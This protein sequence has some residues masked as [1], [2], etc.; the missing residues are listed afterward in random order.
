MLPGPTLIKKCTA[1]CKPIKEYT[2]A[3]GNTGGATHWTDGKLEAPMLPDQPWLVMCPHCHTALWLDE[4]EELGEIQ[5]WGPTS[6]QFADAREFEQPVLNDYFALL[7]NGVT[8]QEKARYVRRRTW[9]AGNDL[10]RGKDE[11]VPMSSLEKANLTAYVCMLDESDEEE[12]VLKAEG[13]REL[14]RFDE[15]LSLLWKVGDQSIQKAVKIIKQLAVERDQYVRELRFVNSG[16]VETVSDFPQTTSSPLIA[17]TNNGKKSHL[18]GM[19]RGVRCKDL[20]IHLIECGYR[21][22]KPKCRTWKSAFVFR[23]ENS[24]LCVL[25]RKNGIDLR[26]YSIYTDQITIDKYN[27]LTMHGGELYKNHFN[28]SGNLI[29]QK[30]KVI[31]SCFT[32][33]RVLD[34]MRVEDGQSYLLNQKYK[35]IQDSSR[36]RFNATYNRLIE[37][38]NWRGI[39]EDCCGYLGDDVWI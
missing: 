18:V 37:D 9:W 15:A 6:E 36:D 30:I 17:S 8:N 7:M 22:C 29:T 24:V 3:F 23:N 28:E 35:N 39:S 27:N 16:F 20:M 14:S 32:K 2:I 21:Y 26:Y 12:L 4:L 5:Y 31:S 19:K 33:G 25:F 1:C 11:E 13:L 34:E 10:R 38:K